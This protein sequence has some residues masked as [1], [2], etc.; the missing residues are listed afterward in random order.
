MKYYERFLSVTLFVL[1]HTSRL[2][3]RK[4]NLHSKSQDVVL[5]VVVVTRWIVDDEDLRVVDGDIAQFFA[6][7][8]TTTPAP[9]TPQISLAPHF[10]D[11]YQVIKTQTSIYQTLN[12][13]AERILRQV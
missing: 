7:G 1:V 3:N 13:D 4:F 9:S 10:L 5:P 2:I 8:G 12:D 11:L 6:H